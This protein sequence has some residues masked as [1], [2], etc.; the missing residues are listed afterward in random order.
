MVFRVVCKRLEDDRF[1]DRLK[2]VVRSVKY[3]GELELGIQAREGPPSVQ[4]SR[5]VGPSSR[6]IGRM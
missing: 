4:L 2:G 6:V 1:T 3:H 5:M